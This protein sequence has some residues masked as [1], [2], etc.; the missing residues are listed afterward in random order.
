MSVAVATMFDYIGFSNYSFKRV[1]NEEF[2][3]PY[4]YT[5]DEKTVAEVLQDLAK[6][7]QYAMFFDENNNLVI[8]SK[9]YFLSSDRD[10]DTVLSGNSSTPHYQHCLYR[11]EEIQRWKH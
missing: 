1:D 3:I 7:A 4:F 11:K 2:T 9:E 6:A 5:S 8:M 10:I